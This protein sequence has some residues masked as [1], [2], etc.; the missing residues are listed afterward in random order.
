MKKILDQ[1]P[2]LSEE[3]FSKF[4]EGGLEASNFLRWFFFAMFAVASLWSIND[5]NWL[6]YVYPLMTL[7]WMVA[8]FI[9]RPDRQSAGRNA[10]RF[11]LLD[12]SIITAG[13]FICALNLALN[14]KGSVIF[15]CYFPVLA[16]AA[17]SLGMFDVLRGAVFT[18]FVYGAFS[19]FLVG[20]FPLTRLL[21]LLAMAIAAA[22]LSQRP[23]NEIKAYSESLVAQAY[24]SGADDR[25]LE[26]LAGIREV[27]FPPPQLD[28]PGIY[29]T[30]KHKAGL[31]TSGDI[32]LATVS[33]K[34]PVIFLGDLGLA[35]VKGVLQATRLEN[36]LR[37][38]AERDLSL[39]EL[40]DSFRDLFVA[41]NLSVY[42]FLARWEGGE[43]KYINAGVHPALYIIKREIIPLEP[44]APAFGVGAPSEWNVASLSVNSGD[45]LLVYTDGAY[46]GLASTPASGALEMKRLITEFHGGEVNTLCHRVFDCGQP[47]FQT[48]ADDSTVVVV[49]KQES[50]A[51]ARDGQ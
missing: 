2:K 48:A 25:Q 10:S 31:E 49:R 23:R 1:I 51:M 34:G 41:E 14:T 32:Y 16:L 33:P 19:I 30:F 7:L 15:L 4:A 28:L 37:L 5:E 12:L 46:S 47:E 35:D 11:L 26:L 40:A 39:T 27:S 38:R 22:F 50:P 24:K 8:A 36:T 9:T 43:L 20:V 17:R 29:T 45:L 21:A 13:L 44:T 3:A 42:G 18:V 6:I